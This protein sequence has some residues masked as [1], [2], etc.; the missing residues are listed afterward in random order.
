MTSNEFFEGNA[1][2]V[3]GMFPTARSVNELLNQIFVNICHA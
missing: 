1:A 2:A 3:L